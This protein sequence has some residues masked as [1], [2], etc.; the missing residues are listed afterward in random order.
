[1]SSKNIVSPTKVAVRLWNPNAEMPLCRKFPEIRKFEIERKNFRKN[2]TVS[3]DKIIDQKGGKGL[4]KRKMFQ[5]SLI[6]HQNGN[7]SIL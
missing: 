2:E 1:M 7:Y 3:V 4:E 5:N 6:K